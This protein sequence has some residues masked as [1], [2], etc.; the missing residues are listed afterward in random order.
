MAADPRTTSGTGSSTGERIAFV[1]GAVGTLAGVVI[2]VVAWLATHST[3]SSLEI[4]DYN[5]LGTFAIALTIVSAAVLV[6]AGVRR[7]F[8]YWLTRLVHEQRAQ[9]D[10]IVEG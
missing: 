4:A 5:A 7:Y 8:R 6:L 3:K 10:R 2:T 1:L 9:V